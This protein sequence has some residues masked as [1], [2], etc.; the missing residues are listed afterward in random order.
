VPHFGGGDLMS[1]RNPHD[2]ARRIRALND[3]FRRNPQRDGRLMITAGVLNEGPDFVRKCMTTVKTFDAFDDDNDPWKEHDF[4]SF[5]IDGIRCFW[6]IDY[7]NKDIRYGSPD[8]TDPLVT[9]RVL[10]IMLADEY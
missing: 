2:V 8:P 10:T 4:G 6:K 1:E 9:C 5:E 3:A 7:Y